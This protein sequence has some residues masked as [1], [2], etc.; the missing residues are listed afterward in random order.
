M[1]AKSPCSDAKLASNRRNAQKSTGPQ[2]QQG[3]DVTRYNSL[4]H[5]LRCDLDVLPTENQEQYDHE[6]ATWLS[7]FKPQSVVEMRLA[8]I[9]F[10]ATWRLQRAHRAETALITQLAYEAGRKFDQRQR[11]AVIKA[12]VAIRVKDVNTCYKFEYSWTTMHELVLIWEKLINSFSGATDWRDRANQHERLQNLFNY[13][14]KVCEENV[15][16]L[17]NLSL[18]VT[19]FNEKYPHV[20]ERFPEFTEIVAVSQELYT[21]MED[22][23]NAVIELRDG[24]AD[25]SDMRNVAMCAAMLDGGVKMDHLLKY[26][27]SVDRQLKSAMRELREL[28]KLPLCTPGLQEVADFDNEA[29]ATDQAEPPAPTQE[30]L[31]ETS[32]L[33]T[34][35]AKLD[36]TIIPEATYDNPFTADPPIRASLDVSELYSGKKRESADASLAKKTTSDETPMPANEVIKNMYNPSPRELDEFLAKYAPPK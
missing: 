11:R 25:P 31:V 26:S 3:K 1:S 22:C 21:G 13:T 8:E 14:P 36:A 7:E 16:R 24:F 18:K 29:E 9:A 35:K 34:S 15:Q 30:P 28:T 23:R 6:K 5:G 32:V 19:L 17:A 12:R 33:A 4:K 20:T 2:S 10:N 27:S